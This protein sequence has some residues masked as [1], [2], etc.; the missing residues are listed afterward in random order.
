MQAIAFRA[1]DMRF[2]L[3]I[4][5]VVQVLHDQQPRPA[6]L[7]P[8]AVTGLIRHS[9]ALLPVVD[10]GLLLGGAAAAQR[11]STRL[12]IVRSDAAPPFLFALRA[13]EVLDLIDV[14]ERAP[15]L[16]QPQHR[17]LGDH[18]LDDAEAPQLIAAEALLPEQLRALYVAD[19]GHG[20]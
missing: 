20:D 1:A 10:L 5:Q 2:A 3:P 17:W 4:A 7:A 11:R 16:P 13:E 14:G 18:I 15:G 19:A 6:P 9:R 12:L 8:P